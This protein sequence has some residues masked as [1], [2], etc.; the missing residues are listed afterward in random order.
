[1]KIYRCDRCEKD[2]KEY[3][4]VE[5]WIKPTN[6]YQTRTDAVY[7]LCEDCAKKLDDWLER[8]EDE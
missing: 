4:I 8:G 3:E 5:V 2:L 6:N 7:D 1:M